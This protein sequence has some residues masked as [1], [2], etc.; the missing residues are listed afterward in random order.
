MKN[1]QT[2]FESTDINSL[3][4]TDAIERNADGS[5]FLF[6]LASLHGI[7]LGARVATFDEKNERKYA[8]S[9]LDKRGAVYIYFKEAPNSDK[10]FF[11]KINYQYIIHRSRFEGAAYEVD[12]HGENLTEEDAKMQAEFLTI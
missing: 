5:V 8:W 6:P 11:G 1:F 4:A 9:N 2:F 7:Q 3:D 12:I 10:Y